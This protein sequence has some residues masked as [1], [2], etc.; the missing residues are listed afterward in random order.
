M[1]YI[2]FPFKILIADGGKEDTVLIEKLNNPKNYPNINY[3][4]IKYPFDK[5]YLD[6]YS[7][8]ADV[9]SK[10][11]TP[12]SMLMDNDDFIFPS[13]LTKSINFLDINKDYVSSRGRIDGIVIKSSNKNKKMDGVYGERYDLR[14][15]S[16]LTTVLDNN[17]T[18]DRLLNHLSNYSP[19]Y[20]DVH[21]SNQLS[22]CFRKLKQI[23][24]SDLFIAE[25]I[26]SC[27]TI[28][29]GKINRGE[30][31][32]LIRQMNSPGSSAAEEEESKGDCYGRMLNSSWSTDYNNFRNEIT[33]KVAL[34][35]KISESES[36]KL[37]NDCYKNFMTPQ[38]LNSVSSNLSWLPKFFVKTARQMQFHLTGPNR[39]R[40]LYVKLLSIFI[41]VKIKDK[42]FFNQN[43]IRNNNYKDLSNFFNKELK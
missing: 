23:N 13:G 10:V 40:K 20:Y 37:F 12:Y 5:S 29:Q 1:N 4:Y 17:K 8:L 16:V 15:S 2:H 24:P 43:F 42:L 19:T 35:D 28:T 9:L 41:K 14:F 32:Y 27:I 3:T 33:K 34:Q 36:L 21:R 26:T 6:Y 25:M 39:I 7:K 30:Y 11:D 18:A 31:T 38:L 22:E